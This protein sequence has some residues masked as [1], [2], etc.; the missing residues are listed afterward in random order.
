MN[1]D[2]FSM[3][4]E[5][6]LASQHVLHYLADAV[7]QLMEH[8]EDNPKVNPARFL[9]DY[10]VSVQQG[11]HTLFREYD[12]VQATPHNRAS[13]VRIFWKCFRHIG[14]NG[15]LLNVR[16]YHSLLCLLCPD[17]P[18]H[19]VQQTARI[20]FMEDAMDSLTSFADF[21]YAFQVQFYYE[22]FLQVCFSIY[23]RLI[24][25]AQSPREAVYIPSETSPRQEKKQ[26]R[27]LDQAAPEGVDC[28][29]FLEA[30]A[31]EC[32]DAAYS[33]PPMACLRE[34]LNSAPRVSFY[35][36]LMGLAKSQVIN[37]AIEMLPA[38]GS[39]YEESDQ[40]LTSGQ[41]TITLIGNG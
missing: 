41:S 31:K 15:D 21:L 39:L 10:F 33:H 7:S 32:S 20:I 19:L 8:K 16:E 17:F 40:D 36:F 9:Q 26:P 23:N 5:E 1:V 2:R 24:S 14:E 28:R 18:F 22:D 29:L 3:S 6:Y 13:F 25:S 4:A 27:P 38:K 34:L 30:V 35:G 11:N 37:D 12:F